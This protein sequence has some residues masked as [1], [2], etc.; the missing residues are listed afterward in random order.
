[1]LDIT[2]WIL[3][4]CVVVLASATQALTGF[5]FPL[6]AVPFFILMFDPKWA[7]ALSM[8]L[9]L[10]SLGTLLYTIRQD[11]DWQMVKQM[12]FGALFGVPVGVY[13][14][15]IINVILLKIFVSIVVVF[16]CMITLKNYTLPITD[17]NRVRWFKVSGSL[18]GFLTATI[19]MP[20]PPIILVLTN[21]DIDK[22]AYRATGVAYFFLIY[23]FTFPIMFLSG[24]IS[25]E[26]FKIILYLVPFPIIGMFL[27]KFLFKLVPNELFKKVVI[28]LLLIVAGYSIATSLL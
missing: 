5:G 13:V 3:S 12:L 27:G 25:M 21:F 9:S 7:V 19:G 17:D 20:G 15:S 14:F 6:V 4:A 11:T 18:S 10:L 23:C 2:T 28:I 22:N 1:M 24:V 8:V 26:I 16:M